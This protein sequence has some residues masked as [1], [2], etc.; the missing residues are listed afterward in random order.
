MHVFDPAYAAPLGSFPLIKLS[1]KHL[2]K[3][4]TRPVSRLITKRVLGSL[5]ILVKVGR[6]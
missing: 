2:V 3:K 5:I 1:W 4:I 6:Y